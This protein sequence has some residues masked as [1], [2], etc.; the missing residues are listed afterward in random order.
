MVACWP[1]SAAHVSRVTSL[2]KLQTF[3]CCFPDTFEDNNRTTVKQQQQLKLMDCYST[4]KHIYIY[5]KLLCIS[6]Q[7]L[8]FGIVLSF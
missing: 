4:C 7:S 8:L 6:K 5:I 1:C 2:E 3:C